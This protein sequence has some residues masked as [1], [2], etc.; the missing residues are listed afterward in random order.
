MF[1]NPIAMDHRI[2][3]PL[4]LAI[5]FSCSRSTPVAEIP[6]SVE[7]TVEEVVITSGTPVTTVDL[8]ID[9][10]SCEMMC[11]GAI[12]KALAKLPGVASTEIA[13]VEGEERDHAIVTYDESLVTDAQMIEAVQQLHDGQY[14]VV[15]VKVTKQVQSAGNADTDT[16][17]SSTTN[18]VSVLAPA[19][20]VLPSILTLLTYIFRI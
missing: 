18:A 12:K 1:K 15:A 16:D 4:T 7:R 14:K 2:L 5:L 11:G 6:A 17:K 9:G 8:S 20:M 19:A 10:M 13:F 3:L